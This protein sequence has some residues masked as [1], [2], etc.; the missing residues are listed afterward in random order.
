MTDHAGRELRARAGAATDL[1]RRLYPGAIG[2]LL[3]RE[4]V[5]WVE[6]GHMLGDDW[7]I[8]RLVAHLDQLG[9]TRAA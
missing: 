8:A 4:L 9:S 5:A 7:L 1:A 3:A 6:F 2:E